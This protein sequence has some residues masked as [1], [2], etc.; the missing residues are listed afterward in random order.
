MR[1]AS[2]VFASS[3]FLGAL[4]ASGCSGD[5]AVV[6]QGAACNPQPSGPVRL[7]LLAEQQV[8]V[9]AGTVVEIGVGTSG[10]ISEPNAPPAKLTVIAKDLP[11][12]VTAEPL[13]MSRAGG[14]LRIAALP[15]ARHVGTR[16]KLEL[17]EADNRY[18]GETT[19]LVL[20]RDKAGALD[21]GFGNNGNVEI[22][23]G[24]GGTAL[25]GIAISTDAIVTGGSSEKNYVTSRIALADGKLDTSFGTNGIGVGNLRLEDGSDEL[26][27][28]VAVGPKGEAYVGG[29]AIPVPPGTE[30][31]VARFDAKGALDKAF[32]GSGFFA[33]RYTGGSVP[34]EKIVEL[35][36][37][38]I[39]VQP[40]DGKLVFAG[41]GAEN[42]LYPSF[43]NHAVIARLTE[44]G[45]LD[46]AFGGGDGWSDRVSL[47]TQSE[48]CNA[49]MV[50]AAS[51][52]YCAG[53]T[54]APNGDPPKNFFVWRVK[55]DGG[56]DDSFGQAG[57][58]KIAY[59][60][61][62]VQG[63]AQ[64]IHDFGGKPVV[65]GISNGKAV[66]VRLDPATGVIDPSFNGGKPA[67]LDGFGPLPDTA[68]LSSAIDKDGVVAVVTTSSVNH[69]IVLSRVLADGSV[70]AKLG[71]A[72]L[73]TVKLPAKGVLGRARV[74]VQ[75]DGRIVVGTTIEGRG[76]ALYRL[77]GT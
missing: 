35:S 10:G 26:A 31:Q 71:E 54:Q 64:T 2:S 21:N 6:C 1:F 12:N 24:V 3:C 67:V 72:G 27:E 48:T 28:A 56:N 65:V 7:E 40:A 75:P 32:N 55:A 33:S 8:T 19:I 50:G 36:L 41:I 37:R 59:A 34:P 69:D 47:S 39:A 9:L 66:V 44:G 77:W 45:K 63:E 74:A 73:V 53:G 13:Q 46:N 4:F 52:V 15:S 17:T 42:L 38:G 5:E 62:A 25:S 68:K 76:I 43:T 20:V 60:P 18:V 57:V 22:P 61:T 16:I 30:F 23:G 49:V 29:Y 14:K 11:A 70:D 58:A 51:N